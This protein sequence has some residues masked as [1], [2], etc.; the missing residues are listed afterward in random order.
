MWRAKYKI[1]LDK[2]DTL[3]INTNIKVSNPLLCIRF[4]LLIVTELDLLDTTSKY[5]NGKIFILGNI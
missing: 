3:I 4:I 1:V 5:H 2:F